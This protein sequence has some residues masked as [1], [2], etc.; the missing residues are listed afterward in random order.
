MRAKAIQAFT[1]IDWLRGLAAL[2]VLLF[3]LIL[4]V[5]NDYPAKAV[6]AG[7]L[8][9]WL[10]FGRLDLGKLGVALFFMISGFLIPAT[11]RNPGSSL[12]AFVINRVFRLYP[13][14]WVS[15]LAFLA[16]EVYWL[17][18]PGV[19]WKEVWIN[20][21]MLQGFF[22][23][24][25]LIGGYWTLQIELIFYFSCGV[26]FLL[27]YLEK[28]EALIVAALA[29]GLACAVMRSVS[30]KEL[31]VALFLALALMFLGDMVREYENGRVPAGR[32]TT[33]A[34]AVAIVLVPIC[35]AGYQEAGSRYVATY[36]LAMLVFFGA[37]RVRIR[38]S[39]SRASVRTAGL[40]ADCS[41]SVYL[42]QSPIG[43]HVG[44]H[45][46]ETSGNALLATAWAVAS[47]YAAA[48]LVFRL[49]E[50][51][52]IR[53]GRNLARQALVASP[54]HPL[55][56]V[57]LEPASRKVSVVTAAREPGAGD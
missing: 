4:H 7:S 2:L 48:Y 3:H 29:G 6:P 55:K 20:V 35:L 8:T 11:L 10:I 36:W 52:C 40:L 22:G 33:M 39:R 56:G 30:G 21:S 13:A 23:V 47:T 26:L 51:P 9:Y 24:P 1:F 38:A 41:Y 5:F 44:R 46:Y 45:V 28:H 25:N 49:V 54:A 34:L 19:G 57:M 14:Y 42:L 37:F 15:I 50:Q 27:K 17:S 31:P 16:V 18:L 43:L 12:K 53:L 32:L